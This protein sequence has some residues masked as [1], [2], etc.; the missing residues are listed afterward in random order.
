MSDRGGKKQRRVRTLSE[1]ER[2]HRALEKLV[3]LVSQD[4]YTTYK[5]TP[6]LYLAPFSTPELMANVGY[7]NL[8]RPRPGGPAV[9]P[10]APVKKGQR[11]WRW[12]RGIAQIG[13]AP[14]R[15]IKH[16]FDSDPHN[17]LFDYK[18]ETGAKALTKIS[19]AE[20]QHVWDVW[21]FTFNSYRPEVEVEGWAYTW[22]EYNDE[23]AG[24]VADDYDG[25]IIFAFRGTQSDVDIA[26]DAG[27]VIT[28]PV[29]N[30]YA[31][32]DLPVPVQGA[33]GPS[34]R[35][36]ALETQLTPFIDKLKTSNYSTVVVTGHS[37]GGG[38]AQLFAC[39]LVQI[40]QKHCPYLLEKPYSFHSKGF[41]LVTY[42]SMRGVTY[43]TLVNLLKTPE[44]QYLDSSNSIRVLN[45][46]DPVPNVPPL[47]AGFAHVGHAFYITGSLLNDISEPLTNAI[48]L[49]GNTAWDVNNGPHSMIPTTK[50]LLRI[51]D[52]YASNDPT[53]VDDFY[54][55]TGRGCVGRRF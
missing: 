20:F 27:S 35:V 39:I 1:D 42:E 46:K 8:F 33:Y 47:S 28:G 7:S 19:P 18:A 30:S 32:E 34:L 10:H 29:I 13:G 26:D 37:L 51:A 55:T 31:G 48:G 45:S 49:L 2:R 6:D 36:E 14:Y 41:H 54:L 21:Q 16:K 22:L 4:D 52:R 3:P 15:M 44:G 50:I 43:N 40:I 11:A 53:L 5:E 24:F 38:T 17:L 9:T 12:V 25:H 23:N